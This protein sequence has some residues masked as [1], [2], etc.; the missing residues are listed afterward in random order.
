MTTYPQEW[1]DW[2]DQQLWPQIQSMM[3]NDAFFKLMG[4]ARELTGKFN[5][6]IAGL[7]E[8]GYVASQMI[9]IRRLC[10]RRKDVISL[11][12]LFMDSDSL[13]SVARM[14]VRRLSKKLDACEH[15]CT[16][17]N[18]Y[19]AHTANPNRRSNVADWNLQ[20]D[21]LAQSHK[22]LCEA[23]VTFDRDILRRKN[24]VKLIP[25]PQY[26]ILQ[27]FRSWVPAETCQLMLEFWHEHNRIVNAWI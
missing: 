20:V 11:R 8:T 16:L 1:A 22:A 25:I 13:N 7:V 5:G 9:T 21:H 23:A 2:L 27:D 19:L 15:V 12:R 17:A 26:D 6:P 3:L 24:Y 10:D 14:T 4:K 18:D